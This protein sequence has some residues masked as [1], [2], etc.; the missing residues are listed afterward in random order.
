MLRVLDQFGEQQKWAPAATHT[1][2]SPRR[3]QRRN[4]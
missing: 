1:M 2:L 3:L 4:L